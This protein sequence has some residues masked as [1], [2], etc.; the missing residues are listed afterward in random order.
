MQLFSRTDSSNLPTGFKAGWQY[1]SRPFGG[2]VSDLDVDFDHSQPYLVTQILS[3]C[4]QLNDAACSE[5][6]VW[7]WTLKKRL[8]ALL[9]VTMVTRGKELILQ[10]NC[11][12][13]RCGERFELPLEL[14]KFKEIPA[15]EE[16]EF[17]VE[18]K[19]IQL[20]LPN[21]HDQRYWLQH[22]H[23]SMAEIATKLVVSVNNEPPHDEWQI[24]AEW[25]DNVGEMLEVHDHLMTLRFDTRCP[26]CNEEL[27]LVVDLEAQL[28]ICLQHAQQKLL[29]E[30]H[31]LAMAY[32]WSER[33]IL[34]LTPSRRR[35]YL[36][37]LYHQAD[38]EE[39]LL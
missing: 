30:I 36:A 29:D 32:H 19:S 25:L 17:R 33:D 26:V 1:I 13:S 14:E 35:F 8:Q 7:A 15:E 21:G 34:L 3:N 22:Q 10:V 27:G 4:L 38:A 20:R 12:N 28:L 37:R 18:D 23:E 24:P 9:E 2:A 39:V 31:Q 11:L 6:E 5:N 16:F